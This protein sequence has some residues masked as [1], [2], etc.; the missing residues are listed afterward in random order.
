M[1]IV[2]P[3]SSQAQRP[4]FPKSKCKSSLSHL[5]PSLPS[6]FSIPSVP[7]FQRLTTPRQIYSSL[8]LCPLLLAPSSVSS[9][10][11][12]TP[13]PF[14]PH[15]CQDPRRRGWKLFWHPNVIFTVQI[16]HRFNINVILRHFFA[17]HD[18]ARDIQPRHLPNRQNLM[19]YLCV[20]TSG[21]FFSGQI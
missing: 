7:F 18:P 17:H 10:L 16:P 9:S 1:Y 4:S 2:H 11:A 5:S 15:I 14:I 13:T 21:P 19:F 20:W 12:H 3:L 6:L 8:T